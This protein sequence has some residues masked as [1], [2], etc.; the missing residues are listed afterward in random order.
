MLSKKS[1]LPILILGVAAVS[2]VSAERP[3]GVEKAHRFQAVQTERTKTSPVV[4]D[5]STESDVP[6]DD[7]A[8]IA[9]ENN[10]AAQLEELGGWG[11]TYYYRPGYISRPCYACSYIFGCCN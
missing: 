6:V 7:F 5:T 8:R 2:A 9:L 3:E 4:R 1:F 10:A 11:Y